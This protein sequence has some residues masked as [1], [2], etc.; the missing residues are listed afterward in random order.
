MG[1]LNVAHI[2][3]RKCGIHDIQVNNHPIESIYWRF[4][5]CTTHIRCQVQDLR[6]PNRLIDLPKFSRLFYRKRTL[7]KRNTIQ[8]AQTKNSCLNNSITWKRFSAMVRILGAS[9]IVNFFLAFSYDLH[10]IDRILK[11]PTKLVHFKA[12]NAIK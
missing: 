7:D 4:I 3:T 8:T 2:V 11:A 5:T 12:S 1:V 6:K 10:L 9:S